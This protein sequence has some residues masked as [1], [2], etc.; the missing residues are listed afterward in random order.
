MGVLQ[1][2]QSEGRQQKIQIKCLNYWFCVCSHHCTS[3][4]MLTHMA[5]LTLVIMATQSPLAGDV[6]ERGVLMLTLMLLLRLSLGISDLG[7][8]VTGMLATDTVFLILDGDTVFQALDIART[9]GSHIRTDLLR[10]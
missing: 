7:T 9:V 10:D 4:P 5:S 2:S 6:K 3:V 1:L 8:L